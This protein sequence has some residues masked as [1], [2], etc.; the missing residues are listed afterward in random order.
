MAGI[1]T[2]TVVAL[3]C[4]DP[5]RLAAFYAAIT[6]WPARPDDRVEWVQLES[7]EGATIAFQLAPDHQPPRWPDPAYPQ[8]LHLDFAVADL[9]AA[10]EQVVALGARKADH[11]PGGDEFRVYLD[12]AGHPFCLCL[13]LAG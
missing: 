5:Q 8:Q 13:A 7:P 6:G 10:E 9:D 1:A 12:P 11:Q 2:F 3:D 4:P